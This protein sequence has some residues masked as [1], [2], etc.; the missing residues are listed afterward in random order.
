MATSH[1]FAA[2]RAA[3]L[4]VLE[5]FRNVAPIAGVGVTK[6]GDGYGVKVDL[7]EPPL[8]GA[9]VPVD[10]DGIPVRVEVVRAMHPG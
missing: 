2:A 9:S 5:I 6:V 10:V 3:K 1:T 4:R 8:P 7:R